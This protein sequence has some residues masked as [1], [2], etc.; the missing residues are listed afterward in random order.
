M[1]V[2]TVTTPWKTPRSATYSKYGEYC[3]AWASTGNITTRNNSG[4]VLPSGEGINSKRKTAYLVG[5]NYNLAI[6]SSATIKGIQVRVRRSKTTNGGTAKDYLLALRNGSTSSKGTIG[7]NFSSGTL[8]THGYSDAYY[9]GSS[10]KLG[11]TLTPAVLNSSTFGVVLRAIGTVSTYSNVG[12]D[13]IDIRVTYTI[14]TDTQ[15]PATVDQTDP[16]NPVVTIPT[17]AVSFGKNIYPY[18]LGG[19]PTL[20]TDHVKRRGTEASTYTAD[21]TT[22]ESGYYKNSGFGTGYTTCFYLS[23]PHVSDTVLYGNKKFRSML[24]PC[25]PNQQYTAQLTGKSPAK[26]N[27]IELVWYTSA[28]AWISTNTYSLTPTANTDTVIYVTATSPSNAKY[29]AV[30]HTVTGLDTTEYMYTKNIQVN[31]GGYIN[32]RPSRYHVTPY[33]YPQTVANQ[34]VRTPHWTNTANVINNNENSGATASAT[35]NQNVQTD[36]LVGSNYGFA[37]PSDA[38]IKGATI[39][40]HRSGGYS[41]DSWV[42]T[43]YGTNYAYNTYNTS[44]ALILSTYG[45]GGNPLDLG[46][47]TPAQINDLNFGAFVCT[48]GV[49][50]GSNTMNVWSIGMRIQYA[51]PMPKKTVLPEIN[52]IDISKEGSLSTSFS[53]APT[54]YLHDIIPIEIKTIPNQIRRQLGYIGMVTLDRGHHYG[55]ITRK[56]A[57]VSESAGG[58]TNFSKSG[59]ISED[60]P[61]K[62]NVP[63]NK[64]KT[65]E[66][67]VDIQNVIPINTVIDMDINDPY[68]MKGYGILTQIQHSRVNQARALADMDVYFV[69]KDLNTPLTVDYAIRTTPPAFANLITS[70]QN[71]LIYLEDAD[72]SDITTEAVCDGNASVTYDVNG[73]TIAMDSMEAQAYYC[74]TQFSPEGSFITKFTKAAT[75]DANH[76]IRQSICNSLNATEELLVVKFISTTVEISTPYADVG[77]NRTITIADMLT[78]TDITCT[79]DVGID[80]MATITIDVNHSGTITTYTESGINIKRTGYNANYKSKLQFINNSSTTSYTDQLSTYGL[81]YNMFTDNT[82]TGIRNVIHIPE[83]DKTNIAYD[84]T[85]LTEEG[86]CYCYIN[87]VRDIIF[88]TDPSKFFDGSVKLFNQA[89]TQLLANDMAIDNNDT[90]TL[91]NGIIKVI[92][93]LT[94]KTIDFYGFLYGWISIGRLTLDN[95]FHAK[96]V[97]I[98]LD[99]VSIQVGETTWTLRRGK[100]Y[101]VINHPYD[102]LGITTI[103]DTYWHDN[104]AGIGVTH[105]I[106]QV[107]EPLNMGTLFYANMYQTSSSIGMMVF[108]P[109]LDNFACNKITKSTETGIGWYNKLGTGSETHYNIA[110]EYLARSTQDVGVQL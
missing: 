2:T 36:G 9:G 102:D 83:S 26:N 39:K 72:L 38:V 44:G 37:L 108:R 42:S 93:D 6:P 18:E 1:A 105:D 96:P 61:L 56:N 64:V 30:G 79:I 85:R 51:Q 13:C 107:T 47:K 29:Y 41:K 20:M 22:I 45:D 33:K 5:Y 73:A 23:L 43:S 101:V 86:L 34:N 69:T 88:Q 89:G 7:R 52:P 98:S 84:F 25:S 100:P 78:A 63:M 27:T 3:A 66:G 15:T 28:G 46:D 82:D 80:L 12:V 14:V 109:N 53:Q 21:A 106:A 40:I 59:T 75:A 62:I 58:F 50:A 67:L 17:E 31:T 99:C 91:T 35:G 60:R 57:L 4:A 74:K 76:Y 16:D 24:Q 32:Y 8:W 92:I 68:A 11:A 94:N 97:S 49:Y 10:D 77:T 90:L 110:L 104:G 55:N 54:Q 48:T 87:P 95:T 70:Y 19:S 65:L 103:F 71:S 81:V